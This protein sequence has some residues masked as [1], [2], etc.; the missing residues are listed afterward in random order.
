[1]CLI[2]LDPENFV[3]RVILGSE[4]KQLLSIQSLIICIPPCDSQQ[5][6]IRMFSIILFLSFSVIPIGNNRSF[7]Q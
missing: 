5:V 6:W 2:L 1:M 4:F 7:P 3:F